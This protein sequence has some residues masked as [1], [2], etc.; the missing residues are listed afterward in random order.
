M[1]GNPES[2]LPPIVVPHTE[3]SAEALTGVIESFVLREGTD[4]GER[5]VPFATKVMQVRRQLERREA[6]IVFDPDTG[7]VSIVVRKPST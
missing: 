4:Y 7:S 6:Q 3:L 1:N 2:P 5:D